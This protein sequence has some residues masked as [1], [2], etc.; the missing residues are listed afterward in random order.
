[1]CPHVD[2]QHLRILRVRHHRG[3]LSA[4]RTDQRFFRQRDE[5]FLDGQVGIVAPTVAGMTGLCTAFFRGRRDLL[6]IEQIVGTV[7]SGRL[8]RLAAKEFVLQGVDLAARLVKLLLQLLDA[9]DGLG[10]LAFPI[11]HF[12]TKI[13]SATAPTPAP[14]A[15]RQGSS[16]RKPTVSGVSIGRSR[17]VAFIGPRYN[18]IDRLRPDQFPRQ[19]TPMD[20]LDEAL[21]P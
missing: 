7:A 2:L 9:F 20:G 1:M 10:M 18:Q 13:G 4:D 12:P 16:R 15:A 14:D 17:S 3:R 8:L 6:G 11:A 5:L 21:H 19:S